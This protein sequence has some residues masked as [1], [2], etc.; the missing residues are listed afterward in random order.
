MNLTIENESVTLRNLM[1]ATQAQASR[2]RDYE[3]PTTQLQCRTVEGSPVNR[4]GTRISGPNK[5]QVILEA[6]HGEATK[7]LEANPVAFNQLCAKAGIDVRTARRFQKDYPDVLDLALNRI[8]QA[9]PRTALLRTFDMTP[10]AV[11]ENLNP[12]ISHMFA[13]GRRLEA[14]S[15]TGMLRAVLTDRFKTFDHPDLLEAVLPTLMESDA[16]WQIVNAAITDKRLYARF[17]SLVITGEGASVGDAMAQGIVISNSETGHGSISIAQ[18]VWTLIC[19]N[20][21]ETTNKSRSTHLTSAR[22][23][24]EIYKMLTD[25]T[26]KLDNQVLAAKVRDITATFASR[27]MFEEVLEQMRSAAGDRVVNGMAVAQPAVEA[28]G[29]ILALT[30]AETS[31]VFDGLLAT[32][33]QPGYAGQPLSRATMVNAVTGAA[34]NAALDDVSEWHRRGSK[35]LNL[36]ANQWKAV[37]EVPLPVAVAA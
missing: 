26:K 14:P 19:L 16:Q 30:R 9:E 1:E 8:Y 3:G 18:L 13:D 32:V 7:I 35:V 29:H 6:R 28:L 2:K 12:L 21:M 15:S 4:N 31:S 37:S 20:G 10:G 5:T 33:Q 36:P 22:A 24:S 34:R 25:K 11:S 23:E 17:K 27:E